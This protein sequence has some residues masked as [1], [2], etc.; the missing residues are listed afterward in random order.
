MP[1]CAGWGRRHAPGTAPVALDGLGWG[2]AGCPWPQATSGMV[3]TAMTM[4]AWAGLVTLRLGLGFGQ[5]LALGACPW[6]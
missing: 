5:L 2:E 3:L 4:T 1:E 6:P